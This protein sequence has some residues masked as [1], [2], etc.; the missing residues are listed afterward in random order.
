MY[1]THA[2]K[3][4][5]YDIP[6]WI[7]EYDPEEMAGQIPYRSTNKIPYSSIDWVDRDTL[8]VKIVG[9]E[10]INFCNKFF[11][12]T[13][14]VLTC[15]NPQGFN[16]QPLDTFHTHAQEVHSNFVVLVDCI[17]K[18]H[19]NQALGIFQKKLE[20]FPGNYLFPMG[21]SDEGEDGESISR[22]D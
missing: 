10:E 3:E 1:D 4:T 20:L 13:D 2:W 16:L 12:V 8:G 11:V 19:E 17:E 7:V 14:I 22:V 6:F 9:G 21:E 5:H 15:G 18:F